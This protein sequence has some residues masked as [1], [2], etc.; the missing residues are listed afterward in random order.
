V[1]RKFPLKRACAEHGRVA[2]GDDIG[3]APAVVVLIGERPGLSAVDSLGV[4]L[5]WQPRRADIP[6]GHDRPAPTQL[7]ISCKWRRH[8]IE[9]VLPISS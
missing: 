5:T 7:R 8:G 6:I 1:L 2:L 3:E 9:A 4:Y